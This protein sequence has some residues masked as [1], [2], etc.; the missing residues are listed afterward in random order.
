MG[1]IIKLQGVTKEEFIKR[2]QELIKDPVL[3]IRMGRKAR[4]TIEEGYSLRV[5]GRRLYKI[6]TQI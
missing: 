6:V 3:R 2:M 4:Q 1:Q 5:L